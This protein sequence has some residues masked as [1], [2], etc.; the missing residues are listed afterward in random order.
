[1][2]AVSLHRDVLVV[3]SAVLQVNCVIVRGP[4]AGAMGMV[5]RSAPEGR[6]GSGKS[7]VEQESPV[8]VIEPGGEGVPPP[9][10]S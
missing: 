2:R 3:T 1:M 6:D 9:R 7:C 4:V 5:E 10:S 8:R